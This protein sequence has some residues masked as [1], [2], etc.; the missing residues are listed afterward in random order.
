MSSHQGVL[1]AT[2]SWCLVLSEGVV[3]LCLAWVGLFSFFWKMKALA[4]QAQAVKE[5]EEIRERQQGQESPGYMAR[6]ESDLRN[7]WAGLL[8]GKTQQYPALPH[9]SPPA[10]LVEET[11]I[12]GTQAG[13]SVPCHQLLPKPSQPCRMACRGPGLCWCVLSFFTCLRICQDKHGK[14]RDFLRRWDN[15]PLGRSVSSFVS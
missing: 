5:G 12:T 9:P 6:L 11:W 13:Q 3:Y 14:R 7:A 10:R 4:W 2:K 15:F 1:S 8:R